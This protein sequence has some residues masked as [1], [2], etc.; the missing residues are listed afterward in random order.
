MQWDFNWQD[1][2]LFQALMSLPKG[3][4]IDGELTYDNSPRN[5][6]NPNSPPKRVT[7]GEQSTDEMGSLILGVVPKAASDFDPLVLGTVAF[8]LKTVPLVGNRPLAVSSGIVDGASTLPGAVTPGKI[9]V[10]YG[11]RIGPSTLTGA[12]PAGGG[13]IS[14]TLGG[15]QV[16]FDGIPAPLLYASSGQV[17]AVVPYGVDG[18]AGTQ[19][20]IKNG[21]LSSDAIP[22][23]VF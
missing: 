9:V 10:M 4:R 5:L 15:T 7:W 14:T 1:Q 20:Q 8:V 13:A 18:K 17:A 12:T 3:T 6:R 11:D 19:V 22:M 21:S 23:P 16:L 2:Y